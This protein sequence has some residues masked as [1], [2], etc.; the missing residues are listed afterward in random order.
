MNNVIPDDLLIE[1]LIRIQNPKF[2][3]QYST[4]S[5][6]WFSLISNTQFISKVMHHQHQK[7]Q[8]NH[9][10]HS[11]TYTF[12]FQIKMGGN[13]FYRFY[14][15]FFKTSRILNR[16]PSSNCFLNFLP[17]VPGPNKV[18]VSSNDLLLVSPSHVESKI[19]YIC[20]CLLPKTAYHRCGSNIG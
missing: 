19:F 3:I 11:Q 20:H 8:L 12:L 14:Q 1:I 4:V 2:L 17:P 9:E 18:T 5:K 16:I 15:I 7:S 10:N 6:R 13:N